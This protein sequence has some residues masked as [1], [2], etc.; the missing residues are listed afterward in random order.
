M[1]LV[2]IL[3]LILFITPGI[4]YYVK[5]RIDLNKNR[6]QEGIKGIVEKVEFIDNL[7][8]SFNK[9]SNEMY[10]L[11][12]KLEDGKKIKTSIRRNVVRLGRGN[13]YSWIPSKNDSIIIYDNKDGS[14]G[15]DYEIRFKKSVIPRICIIYSV[16]AIMIAGGFIYAIIYNSSHLITYGNTVVSFKVKSYR[17]NTIYSIDDEDEDYNPENVYAEYISNYNI[18]Y[19][20]KGQYVLNYEKTTAGT[21]PETTIEEQHKKINKEDVEYIFY[22]N[23]E[24]SCKVEAIMEN[25]DNGI[26]YR[27][28]TSRL[29]FYYEKDEERHCLKITD[30]TEN[31]FKQLL[32][33]K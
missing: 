4:I 10:E 1:E 14:Y 16:I 24:V 18:I 6:N 23:E 21:T 25:N 33:R 12:V 22:N 11:T 20:S 8:T 17:Q 19:N 7:G 5:Y 27:Y 31:Y 3:L 28:D 2:T 13:N 30:D 15:N 29:D 32:N 9:L 26:S